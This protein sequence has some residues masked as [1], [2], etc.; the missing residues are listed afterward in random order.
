M[1]IRDRYYGKDSK[2]SA[3]DENAVPPVFLAEQELISRTTQK[4]HATA[5]RILQVMAKGLQ[6]EDP[7]FFTS[8]HL[9]DKPS[10]CVFR[11]L[12]YPLIRDDIASTLDYD[13]TI[14]AAVSYTHLYR[15]AIAILGLECISALFTREESDGSETNQ[16]YLQKNT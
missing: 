8:K 15:L 4:L 3:S 10:G 1:C 11:M 14:R 13:P 7:E 12:R 2:G 9:P 16:F 6:I 5:M